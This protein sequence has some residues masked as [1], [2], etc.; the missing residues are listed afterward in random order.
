MV[1]QDMGQSAIKKF[2]EIENKMRQYLPNTR[3]LTEQEKQLFLSLLDQIKYD[4]L[5]LNADLEVTATGE[6]KTKV[7]ESLRIVNRKLNNI[8]DPS[9]KNFSADWALVV[10]NW[11]N[12][13]GRRPDYLPLLQEIKRKTKTC[14]RQAQMLKDLSLVEQKLRALAQYRPPIFELSEHYLQLL[15]KELEKE[16]RKEDK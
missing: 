12:Q 13:V 6:M 4:F 2:L 11:N 7:K 8:F 3:F 16:T 5:A 14:P 15:K 9:F 10:F 1:N